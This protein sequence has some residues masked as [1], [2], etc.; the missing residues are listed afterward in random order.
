M[1]NT[2]QK[3]QK[4]QKKKTCKNCEKMQKEA[5]K[6]KE[7]LLRTMA[8]LQNVRRR[9]EEEK[10][11]LPQIGAEKIVLSLLPILDNLELALNNIPQK[12]DDWITGVENIFSG[13]FTALQNEGLKKID[14]KNIPVNP[15]KHEVLMADPNGK[16]GIVSEVLQ[17]GYT[18]KGKVIRAAKVKAGAQ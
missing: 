12:K 1:T 5:E 4:R 18:L 6:C 8:D 13:L 2:E 14:E 9:A 16:P 10:I 15:D 17:T 7:K 3:D 11:R